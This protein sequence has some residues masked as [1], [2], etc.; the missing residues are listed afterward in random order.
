MNLKSTYVQYIHYIHIVEQ[1][2]GK[3]Q[4]VEFLKIYFYFSGCP[5]YEEEIEG[6]GESGT[7]EMSIAEEDRC[8]MQVGNSAEND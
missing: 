2:W 7:T 5:G 4:I 8:Q 1:S 3:T 6:S